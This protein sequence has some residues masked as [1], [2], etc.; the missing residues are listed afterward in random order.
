[1]SIDSS[2]IVREDTLPTVADLTAAI[3]ETGVEVVFPVDFALNR[4]VGGWVPITVDGQESGFDYAAYPLS[5]VGLGELPAGAIDL[6]DTLLSFG[7]RGTIS[8]E[9]V[10]LIQQV[11]GRRWRAALL[12]EDELLPPEGDWGPEASLADLH[13][14]QHRSPAERAADVEAYVA[15]HYPP[16]PGNQR[17]EVMNVLRPLII[18]VII[19]LI[20]AAI[21]VWTRSA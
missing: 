14:D 18:P 1:M 7:A 6:G 4:N 8:A 9:T 19:I 12:I 10:T 16:A 11:L 13:V 2:L 21:F 5:G 17:A 15:Q 3:A 20:F